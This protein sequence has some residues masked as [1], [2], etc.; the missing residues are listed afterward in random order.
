[1]S[2]P[3]STHYFSLRAM[4]D[5]YMPFV[6][7]SGIAIF[8]AVLLVMVAFS[9]PNAG[10]DAR[11]VVPLCF[12]VVVGAAG[13]VAVYYTQRVQKVEI[14]EDRLAWIDADGEHEYRWEDVTSV[15]RLEKITNGYRQTTL[16]IRFEDGKQ[17][18]FTHA[19]SEYD[20]LALQ[21]QA[22]SASAALPKTT[23]QLDKLGALSFGAV[24]ISRAGVNFA[25]DF[26]PW[27]DLDYGLVNGHLVLSTFAG[28][29]SKPLDEIP[30]YFLMLELM[31][32]VGK[33]AGNPGDF[34]PEVRG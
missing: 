16:T 14:H 26:I 1:M 6:V 10:I 27:Q 5:R 22:L 29:R 31:S 17:A 33:P 12:L 20:A 28:R 21:V 18:V 2:E 8:I 19:L 3:I 13:A 23:Q 9:R 30:N 7:L 15:H 25:G 34:V 32:R 11:I 24:Q 4:A